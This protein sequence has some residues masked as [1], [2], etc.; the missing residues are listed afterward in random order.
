M[1]LHAV[2][3]LGSARKAI[4][5]APLVSAV[6]LLRP[7]AS[8]LRAPVRQMATARA[9][10][11]ETA[12]PAQVYRQKSFKRAMEDPQAFEN[13]RRAVD[14]KKPHDIWRYYRV[15]QRKGGLRKLNN[16]SFIQILNLVKFHRV[17]YD[18]TDAGRSR[19]VDNLWNDVAL[20]GVNPNWKLYQLFLEA[21]SRVGNIDGVK[22]VIEAMK[23]ARQQ[24]ETADVQRWLMC[25]C[26]RAGDSAQARTIY[27]AYKTRVEGSEFANLLLLGYS[28]G[29]H[30]KELIA[31][32]DEMKASGPKPNNISYLHVMSYYT[33]TNNLDNVLKYFAERKRTLGDDIPSVPMYNYIISSYLQAGKL[34]KARETLKEM[35]ARGLAGSFRTDELRLLLA[36][37]EGNALEAWK[38]FT[39]A[40]I[41][42][43]RAPDNQSL[44]KL[45]KATGPAKGVEGLEE[46][47]KTHALAS[48]DFKP[49]SLRNLLKGYRISKDPESAET[50]LSWFE[51][52]GWKV[53][54]ASY[55]DVI[56]AYAARSDMDNTMR[57]LNKMMGEGL[58]PDTYAYTQFLGS[59]MRN[60]LTDDAMALL[61]IM[62]RDDTF[63][64]PAIVKRLEAEYGK[65]N[66]VVAKLA[67]MLEAK[68]GAGK[69]GVYQSV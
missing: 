63:I 14:L 56:L 39:G 3:H 68:I 25:A 61:E 1:S 33:H 12:Q 55:E 10:T 28:R 36:A 50:V 37:E 69:E 31:T 43:R 67:A 44:S 34:D 6:G 23:N 27:D 40:F 26:A 66:Q 4:S 22:K 64:K 15:L 41:Q 47:K 60:G 35:E 49:S 58:K 65:E 42:A 2:L 18:R 8:F 59:M 21:Y 32:L 11:A 46:L 30:E 13:F 29:K 20:S 54:E 7:A 57:L 9:E 62:Q 16:D 19:V 48:L 53:V 24:V 17:F 51:P 38:A 52:C 45:A 5:S